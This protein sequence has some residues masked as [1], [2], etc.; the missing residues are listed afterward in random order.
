MRRTG[1]RSILLL[2]LFAAAG[3]RVA[4]ASRQ[5]SPYHR[6]S[7]PLQCQRECIRQFRFCN[8]IFED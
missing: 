4:A 6:A 5:L 8:H 3:H 2:A 1:I 7:A